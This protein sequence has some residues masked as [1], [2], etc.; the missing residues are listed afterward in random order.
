MRTRPLGGSAAIVAVAVA[1]AMS[2]NLA[3]QTTAHV[4]PSLGVAVV[5]DSNLLARADSAEADVISRLRPAI[6][7]DYRSA[8]VTMHGQLTADAERF[9]QNTTLTTVQARQHALFDIRYR[10]RPR[11]TLGGETSYAM[12]ATPGDLNVLSGL[13]LTRGRARRWTISPAVTGQLS[14][15]TEGTVK[16][17]ISEDRLE[18][19][20]PMATRSATVAGVHRVSLRDSA[21][22]D[23]EHR[24]FDFGPEGTTR[25]HLLSVGWTRDVTRRTSVSMSGGPRIGDGTIRPA[26]SASV[27]YQSPTGEVSLAYARVQTTL[28]G[29][30]GVAD[31]DAVSLTATAGRLAALHFRVRPSIMKTTRAGLVARVYMLGLSVS[32]PI[33]RSL[34][35]DAE[36]DVTSQRGDL[37]AAQPAAYIARHVVTVGM[38]VSPSR[39]V[40]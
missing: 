30:A 33:G 34:A 13:A 7:A 16:Y 38:T 35:V 9:A 19:G 23:Y 21:R 29:L 4:T 8:R 37:Y 26:L 17:A 15:R 31:T 28:I 2:A 14:N 24:V 10:L 39:V 20:S 32:R 3:A 5:S 27:R 22:V 36:Y 11:L 1:A 25:S 40:P 6:D 12:S 18:K